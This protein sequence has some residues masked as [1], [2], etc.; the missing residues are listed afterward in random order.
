MR[1]IKQIVFIIILC[2]SYNTVIMS[3]NLDSM[4]VAK[5]DSLLIATA[6]EVVLRYGPDYYREDFKPIIERH[7]VP[8]KGDINKTGEMAGRVFYWVIFLYNEEKEQLSYPFAA[9][10]QLWADTSR[11]SSV[12]FGNGLGI[13]ITENSLR[14]TSEEIEPVLYKQRQVIPIYD[15][16]DT[17]TNKK[18]INF[19]EL[20][21]KGYVES[22]N[23]QWVKTRP[24]TPPAEAVKVIAREKAKLK[25]KDKK[26]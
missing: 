2:I 6:K 3:Q 20:K 24:D 5:R 8:S 16:N 23:G 9:R 17:N 11:P 22:S 7:T 26:Q 18:P 15:L 21:M 4:H 10:V 14:S 12:F 1:T 25:E 19:D 13:I